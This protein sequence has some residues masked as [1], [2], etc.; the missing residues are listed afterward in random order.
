M[1]KKTKLKMKVYNIVE[2]AVGR[3]IDWGWQHAHKHVDDPG[4]ELIK[5]RILNDV[6][7]QLCEVVDFDE[8]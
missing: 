8:A 7:I 6:M 5:E 3:G 2:E 4:E 1:A